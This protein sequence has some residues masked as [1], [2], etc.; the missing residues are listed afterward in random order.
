MEQ[1]DTREPRGAGTLMQLR[2][3]VF[4]VTYLK[5]KKQIPVIGKGKH[6]RKTRGRH[7][8]KRG[9][10]KENPNNSLGGTRAGAEG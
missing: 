5:K 4:A 2:C 6:R 9:G 3:Q 1:R 10:P 8:A 7:L